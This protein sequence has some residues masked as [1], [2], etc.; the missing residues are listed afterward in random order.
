MSANVTYW[1]WADVI[2]VQKNQVNFYQVELLLA[3]KTERLNFVV[4]KEYQI[5]K[6]E[7]SKS[8]YF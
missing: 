8:A 5:L 4:S 3:V 2:F 7:V 6:F 1:Y